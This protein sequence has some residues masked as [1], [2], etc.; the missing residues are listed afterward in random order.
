MD[1]ATRKR[2]AA[3]LTKN[4]SKTLNAPGWMWSSIVELIASHEVAYLEHCRLYATP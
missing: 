2:W 1:T 3:E 4:Q